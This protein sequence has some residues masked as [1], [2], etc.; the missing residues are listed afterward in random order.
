MRIMRT[1]P[2]HAKALIARSIDRQDASL[3]VVQPS[4][5][6]VVRCVV[7][8]RVPLAVATALFRCA[9]SWRASAA[10]A[11]PPPLLLCSVRCA[12]RSSPSC[13]A[14]DRHRTRSG[15]HGHSEA[16]DTGSG[17]DDTAEHSR[18]GVR[19]AEQSRAAATHSAID[20]LFAESRP[21]RRFRPSPVSQQSRSQSSLSLTATC[22]VRLLVAASR[23][24]DR[25]ADSAAAIA[26]A[27]VEAEEDS[28]AEEEVEEAAAVDSEEEMRCAEQHAATECMREAQTNHVCRGS[29]ILWCV[30]IVVC[31]AQGPPESVIGAA[32]TTATG[33]LLAPLICS[34]VCPLLRVSRCAHR[35]FAAPCAPSVAVFSRGRC[36]PAPLR[37]RN[38]V[39]IDTGQDSSFQRS[40]LPREQTEGG[41]SRGG[42]GSRQRSVFHGQTGRRD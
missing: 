9:V 32:T 4:P 26:A 14:A 3:A 2:D 30:R 19:R 23:A 8:C 34:A 36:V 40:D 1:R 5:V 10:S 25:A 41:Q 13:T 20:V 33:P 29:H 38:G 28:E 12:E 22:P 6:R 42:A 37:K 18:D 31:C 17:A 15:A 24:A 21:A 16:H 27:E 35:L 39:Q 7:C 11:P